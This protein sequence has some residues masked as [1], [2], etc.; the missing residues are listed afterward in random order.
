MDEQIARKLL[1]FVRSVIQA[2]LT[3]GFAVE[4]PQ[5]IGDVP[6]G[7][8]FVTLKNG[9]LLRGCMGTFAPKETLLDTVESAA[10]SAVADPRFRDHPVTPGE[11]E[12]I[13]VEISVLSQ[14]ERTDR[15]EALEVGRHGIWIRRG[16]S[17][18]CFL[19]QVAS[20]R[21]WSAD[22]F[23]SKCCTMKAGLESEAWRDPDTEVLL[24]DAEI[25][26]ERS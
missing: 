5:D 15:P 2:E 14:P 3:P 1:A 4:R 8:A 12:S 22:E 18:G 6:H 7:G 24:F 20:D 17:S 10:R 13:G 21:G 9:D 23:L 16:G 26:S 19:P 11:M 25:V